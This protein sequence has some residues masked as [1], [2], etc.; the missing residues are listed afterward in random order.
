MSIHVESEEEICL[1][2]ITQ[3]QEI[4]FNQYRYIGKLATAFHRK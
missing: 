3:I 2:Q 4:R 1:N